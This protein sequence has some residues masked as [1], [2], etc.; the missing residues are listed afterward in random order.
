MSECVVVGCEQDSVV[1]AGKPTPWG[2]WKYWV[3][4]DHKAQVDAGAVIN[5]SPDGRTITIAG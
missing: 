5:D 2:A 3:C 1:I 4:A